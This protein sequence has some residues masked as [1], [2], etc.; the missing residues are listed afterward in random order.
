MPILAHDQ[1]AVEEGPDDL[2]DEEGI[3]FGLVE[4]QLTHLGRQVFDVQQ[5]R[6]QLARLAFVQG[7]ENQC[8]V[9]V[10]K[11]SGGRLVKPPRGFLLLRPG[12]GHNH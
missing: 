6:D 4:Y 8:L 11:I 3:T 5:V 2:F 12:N 9:A 7:F 1:A 10:G